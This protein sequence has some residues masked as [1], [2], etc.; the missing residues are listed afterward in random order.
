MGLELLFVIGSMRAPVL[1][2]TSLC[3][4]CL[5][6]ILLIYIYIYIYIYIG[7]VQVTLGVTLS[8]ITLPNNLLLNSY[9]EN[10]TVELHVIYVINIHANFYINWMLF[11]IRSV[12]SF[13]MHYFK[14]Q[15]FEFKQLIDDMVI[16][17]WSPWNF[18]NM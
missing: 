4:L 3:W 2:F 17:F 18:T 14:L 12:N 15:K 8:N 11:T 13:F 10:P 1:L 5:N 7:W 16:N 6:S 9:F